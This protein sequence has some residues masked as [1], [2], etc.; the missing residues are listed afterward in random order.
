M[1]ERRTFLCW[2]ISGASALS[3]RGVR[4]HAQ[5]AALSDASLNTLRALAPAVLPSELGSAGHAKVVSDFVQWLASY[6][7]GAERSWGY[8]APRSTV[9]PPIAVATYDAQLALLAAKARAGAGELPSLPVDVVRTLATATL[10][11]AG[12][13]TLPSSP[14]GTHVIADFMS[15]FFN[16][17]AAHDL[18]YR[19]R[20][21]RSTCR[22]LAGAASRPSAVAGD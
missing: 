1:M 9:T 22:G 16:G 20:I 7:S 11:A 12:V 2:L 14:N 18:V 21:A 3:V 4:L 19:A 15:F 17:N 6:R 10:D 5:A 13:R 8:G